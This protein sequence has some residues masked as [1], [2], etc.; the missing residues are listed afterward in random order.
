MNISYKKKECFWIYNWN[1]GF[2]KRNYYGINEQMFAN[3][4]PIQ[5][6]VLGIPKPGDKYWTEDKIS[7]LKARYPNINTKPYISKL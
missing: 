4:N 2:A 5:R 3:L 6:S 1:K 7:Y